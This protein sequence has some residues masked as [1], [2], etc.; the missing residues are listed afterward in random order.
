MIGADDTLD[1]IHWV[2]VQDPIKQMFLSLTKAIR[3]QAA[4]IRDLDRRCSEMI[5]FDAAERMIKDHVNTCCTKQDATQ[6][7]Y[8]IDTKATEKDVAVLD[9]RIQQA[10]SQ[11]ERLNEGYQTQAISIADMNTRLD[12][13]ARDIHTLKNPNYDHIYAYIDRQVNSVL[14]D[15][16]RKLAIKADQHLV[17]TCIPVRMEDLYRS[18]N[19]KVVD[20][21]AEVARSATK[22]EFQILANTKVWF[23]WRT[24]VLCSAMGV[25]CSFGLGS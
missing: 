19:S 18:L 15:M 5:P 20:L 17:E 8:Q 24:V 7:I 9:S 2:N 16:D 10:F 25:L 23:E 4:G 6:L 3:T 13:I 11:I 22:E 1:D 21:K 14:V 12:S